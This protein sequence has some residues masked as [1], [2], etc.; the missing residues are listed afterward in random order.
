ML[1]TN[2]HKMTHSMFKLHTS[3]QH[4]LCCGGASYTLS[5]VQRPLQHGSRRALFKQCC[6]SDSHRDTKVPWEVSFQAGNSP[7]L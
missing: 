7:N 4:S 3:C 5:D 2:C 1:P 6:D